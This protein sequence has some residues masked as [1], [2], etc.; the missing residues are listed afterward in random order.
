[1]TGMVT[2]A[3]PTQDIGVSSAS[4]VTTIMAAPPAAS[5][6]AAFSPNV[7]S[8][9]QTSTAL[10]VACD[11]GSHPYLSE[12]TVRCIGALS[13]SPT[14]PPK[15]ASKPR[16]EFDSPCT[17]VSSMATPMGVERVWQASMVWPLTVVIAARMT[18]AARAHIAVLRT[19]LTRRVPGDSPSSDAP[20]KVPGVA[21]VP[22]EIGVGAVVEGASARLGCEIKT[23]RLSSLGNSHTRLEASLSP[24][25]HARRTLC[26]M[27]LFSSL[28][29]VG[30]PAAFPTQH[31]QI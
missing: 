6:A 8:P 31:P 13:L 19:I 27:T 14:A 12:A 20:R 9:L 5:T 23:L 17:V 21:G 28:L 22:K 26:G 3:L 4:S 16:K 30:E 29:L 15:N 24:R 25:T 11:I 18:I 10:P 7:H 2:V 1:M